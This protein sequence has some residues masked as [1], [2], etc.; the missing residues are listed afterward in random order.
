MKKILPIL[1]FA[2]LMPMIALAQTPSVDATTII[3]NIFQVAKTIILAV[4]FGIALILLIIAGIKYMTSGGDAEKAGTAR[5]GIINALI[6]VAIVLAAGFLITLAQ[7][8][9]AQV[10]TGV[11]FNPFSNPCTTLLNS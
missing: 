2:A 11:S 8:L 6:G 3:C 9:V 1:A 7:S 10:T 4:G 5:A